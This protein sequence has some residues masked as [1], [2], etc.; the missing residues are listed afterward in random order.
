MSLLQSKA[1]DL[2]V[3]VIDMIVNWLHR[4]RDLLSLALSHSRFY[5]V[6][7][8]DHLHYRQAN[9][10]IFDYAMWNHLLQDSRRVGKLE[11]LNL[12]AGY[13]PR[14]PPIPS[15]SGNET[16]I[17]NDAVKVNS[18]LIHNAFKSTRMLHTV[19]WN[20]NDA[21][22]GPHR[23][24]SLQISLWEAINRY[25]PTVQRV[26][27]LGYYNCWRCL[28]DINRE[29]T[30]PLKNLSQISTFTFQAKCFQHMWPVND[31]Y[32]SCLSWFQRLQHLTLLKPNGFG[33]NIYYILIM[34]FPL[35]ESFIARDSTRIVSRMN[36]MLAFLAAHPLLRT[37]IWN[38]LNGILTPDPLNTSDFTT[39][40][41]TPHLERLVSP[42]NL[43]QALFDPSSD[44]SEVRRP[45]KSLCT[46]LPLDTQAPPEDLALLPGVGPDL[47]EL[48]VSDEPGAAK[49]SCPDLGA[50][51]RIVSS[52]FPNLRLLDLG[53][54]TINEYQVSVRGPRPKVHD[55]MSALSE[56]KY[57]VSLSIPRSQAKKNGLVVRSS[58][59]KR[60]HQTMEHFLAQCPRLRFL[61]C[62][63]WRITPPGQE[64][65]I[66]IGHNDADVRFRKAR[67]IDED[68]SG[69][70]R[71]A[72]YEGSQSDLDE[73]ISMAVKS[74]S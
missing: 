24:M 11:V 36:D 13:Q 62:R 44:G 1:L 31:T 66:L 48:T 74:R 7:V 56:F 45:L 73:E 54:V 41:I 4:Q 50:A 30:S 38:T 43:V 26:D 69:D 12:S 61:F 46:R 57:L 58:P 67:L 63:H 29:V 33:A 21:V 19:I 65:A 27:A 40:D 14:A 16:D 51:L 32:F 53:L 42:L 22:E 59:S 2:P 68:S 25:C 10:C 52:A 20:S 47:E 3:E 60:R 34:R 28:D 39:F 15:L 64:V 72:A 18:E 35:L 49:W 71:W 17:H 6:I 55:W 5:Q 37:F 8:P 9:F 70:R 23:A